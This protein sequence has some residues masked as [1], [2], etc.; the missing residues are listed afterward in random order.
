MEPKIKRKYKILAGVLE[1]DNKRRN[2]KT[3]GR[4]AGHLRVM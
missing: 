3:E 1:N 4:T 2:E